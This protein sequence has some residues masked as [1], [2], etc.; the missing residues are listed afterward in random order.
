MKKKYVVA[1]YFR[2]RHA[3]T[4]CEPT[5]KNDAE[6][7]CAKLQ[8]ESYPLTE[9]KVIKIGTTLKKVTLI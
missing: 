9:Y 1:R 8:K 7:R 6:E 4:V 5:T 2:G 3:A